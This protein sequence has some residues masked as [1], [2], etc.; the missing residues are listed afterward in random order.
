MLHHYV[1]CRIKD[2][3]PKAFAYDM[4]GQEFFQ[5][6]VPVRCRDLVV[7]IS[8][9]QFD[10]DNILRQVGE[11]IHLSYDGSQLTIAGSAPIIEYLK[12]LPLLHDSYDRPLC[13]FDPAV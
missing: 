1:F 6:H 11:Q 3:W 8:E 13:I 12:Q 2:V 10:V 7:F 9:E 5:Y 4:T